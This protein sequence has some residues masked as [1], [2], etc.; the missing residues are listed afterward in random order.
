MK[1][2]KIVI[3]S[4]VIVILFLVISLFRND[5]KTVLINEKKEDYLIN[6]NTIT[7]MY[8][9]ETGSGEYQTTTDTSWPQEGYIFNETLSGCEN[10]K[11]VELYH[12]MM[13]LK[14]LK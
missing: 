8:E 4:I 1:K 13:L 7:M 12:G 6:S 14:K 11:M 3:F 5:N 10:V 2:K 9:T